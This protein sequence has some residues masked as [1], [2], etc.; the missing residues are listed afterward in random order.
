MRRAR[1]ASSRGCRH[2]DRIPFLYFGQHRCVQLAGLL[3][4]AYSASFEVPS[5]VESAMSDSLV[6]PVPEGLESVDR[7]A[8]Y[9]VAQQALVEL[10][11]LTSAT[12]EGSLN[13]H[14]PGNWDAAAEQWLFRLPGPIRWAIGQAVVPDEHGSIHI[15]FAAMRPIAAVL[16]SRTDWDVISD[17]VVSAMKRERVLIPT[18]SDHPMTVSSLGGFVILLEVSQAIRAFMAHP[19]TR[20]AVE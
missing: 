19:R 11:P 18:A 14:L 1:I 12:P 13:E 4:S 7:D 10:V 16:D 15:S 6:V 3:A 5:E 20:Q 17:D 9:R 2:L 8:L